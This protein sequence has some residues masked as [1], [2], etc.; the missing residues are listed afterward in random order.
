MEQKADV[1]GAGLILVHND[2]VLLQLRDNIPNID[3]PDCWTFA[4]AGFMDGDEDPVEA[5]KRELFEETGYVSKKS[6][7]LMIETYKLPDGK[8]MQAHRFYE[9]Y[10]ESQ[11]INCNEGQKMEFKSLAEA[12]LLKTK[13]GVLE[14]MEKAIAAARK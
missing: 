1:F 8:V 12:R 11:K 5:A 7:P 14:V 9:I 6:L 10:D 2:K 3:Y 13:P 4:G